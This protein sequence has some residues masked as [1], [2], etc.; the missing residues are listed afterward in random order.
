MHADQC[1]ILH[2]KPESCSTAEARDASVPSS[3]LGRVVRFDS[4]LDSRLHSV[5]RRGGAR[6]PVNHRVSFEIKQHDSTREVCVS[7][8]SLDLTKF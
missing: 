4:S 5:L 7:M 6:L 3:I 8:H 2:A 1:L